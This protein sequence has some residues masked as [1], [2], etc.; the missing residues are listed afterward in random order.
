MAVTKETYT[1][2]PT[3]T[4][5]GAAALFED[6]FIDANLMTAWHDSFANGGVENRVL[7]VEYDGTKAYG[8]CYYWFV[9]TTTSIGVSV[10]SDWNTGSNVP[11][12]T[13]FLDYL[14]TATNTT[15]NHSLILAGANTATQLDVVRYTSSGNSDYSWF[16]VRNGSVPFPFLI[17]PASAPIVPW[18]D[19]DK[20]LFHHFVKCRLA[21]SSLFGTAS[22][23]ETFKLRRSYLNGYTLR[24]ITSFF[25]Y[26][27]EQTFLTYTAGGHQNGN[28]G[29]YR[30]LQTSAEILVPYGFSATN[31][32]FSEDFTP[33]LKGC[34][35]S[36]Y[37]TEPLPL[38]MGVH[39]PF[40][41]TAFGFGDRIVVS[42]GV[43]EWEVL[44]FVNTASADAS[45]P[46]L[47]ARVV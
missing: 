21:T 46:L 38:D 6:A 13:Q 39:F 45:N 41:S 12:G 8:T 32:E 43:E 33:V 29:N 16:V 20:T 31:P 17:A 3:W 35:F 7:E 34:S 4:A 44:N 10:A 36:P 22:F 28:P 24:E 9:F 27:N 15:A 23:N 30:T 14:E 37:L 19:L 40:T 18:I 25:A 11:S 2:T 42:S 26:N 1:A 5:S 47:V